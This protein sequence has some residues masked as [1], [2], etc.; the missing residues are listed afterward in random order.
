MFGITTNLPKSVYLYF[1]CQ[2]INLM[3]AVISLAVA[4]TVGGILATHPIYSTIPYGLQFAFLLL[5]TYPAAIL[6][7][8]KGRN[9][10]FTVGTIFLLLAGITGY[11]ALSYKSFLLLIFAHG[12][13][14]LFTAFANYYRFAVTDDLPNTLK[15]KAL[16]LVVAG[17][18]I[19][20]ILGPIVTILLQDT[21]GFPRFSLCYGFLVV[22]AVA[23]AIIIYFLPK[24]QTDTKEEK[25]LI[26]RSNVNRQEKL[27]V[28]FY[29][30]VLSASI[31]YGLMN[32][33]MIQSSLQMNHMA[34]SFNHSAI[35]IQWHVVAMFLPSFFTG[36]LINKFGHHKIL[37][38]GFLLF[39]LSFVIN[40]FVVEYSSIM[41]SLIVLG[42]AW[43]FSYVGGSSLLTIAIQN[44]SNK[45]KWQ[46]I[47]DT[48]I[49][50]FATFG[51]FLPSIL[52]STIGWN[53]T[54]MVS[55]IIATIPIL[56][57]I[58]L[59]LKRGIK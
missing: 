53:S 33:L 42:L 38:I 11:L 7:K 39:F 47:C 16:S 43:N 8:K 50:V 40:I 23:N 46:G 48:T 29:L 2:S 20:G 5:G 52:L 57:L 32:L 51:A 6:M 44:N 26:E 15:S 12:F 28:N 24:K 10:G 35:A 31:G 59:I 21:D 1:V 55:M 4:A 58:Q 14:G 13:I 3:S 27:N 56:F 36:I 45:Q 49:A 25:I 17:G 54:N 18:V 19:A 34:V 9:F 41:L 22:L 30:A 37:L